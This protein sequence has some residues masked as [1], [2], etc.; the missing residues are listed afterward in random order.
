M[1]INLDGDIVNECKSLLDN[2]DESIECINTE[3]IAKQD[4]VYLP[5]IF[6]T[7]SIEEKFRKLIEQLKKLE[8]NRILYNNGATDTKTIK[9]TLNEINSDIAY[10]DIKD[11]YESYVDKANEK[12]KEDAI[13]A[14]IK[15]E[16]E[17]SH[18]KLVNYE[19][20]KSN[21]HIAMDA[22]NDD[23]SYIFFSRNRLSLE[24]RDGKYILLSRGQSV[25]PKQ[26]SVGERNAIALCYFFSDIMKNQEE[27]QVYGIPHLLV[28]DD[29]I[30]SY[31][32]E[33]RVG[34][35]SYL[36]YELCKFTAGN[37]ET[38]GLIMTHDLQ[39]LFD[40]N[41]FS[42]EIVDLC[43]NKFTGVGK[44]KVLLKELCNQ[45]LEYINPERRQEYTTLLGNIYN[46][47]LDGSVEYE[48][49][50]GNMMRRVLEAYG[51]FCYK[52]GIEQLS[53]DSEILNELGEPYNRY[54]EN[55]M[56]RIVLNSE[57]HLKER[58][59]TLDSTNFFD[60][61]SVGEK[62][63]T[64]RDVICMMYKLNKLHLLKHL[65]GK[66]GAEQIIE[67]WCTDIEKRTV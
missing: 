55:L 18:K 59:Q 45:N 6:L 62:K 26:I 28:I 50:I 52:K 43:T 54:F 49:S 7:V 39:T 4:N 36:R 1:Y 27:K 66:T 51:T 10:Y 57:S 53:T 44:H 14:G 61:I 47:G 32:M 2:F 31:D 24:Y 42:E 58:V 21:V 38:K 15:N 13:L 46:F 56:Y 30:S 48:L 60:F 63:R 11:I 8:E 65:S 35:L 33:N 25:T 16:L 23:L 9:S 5:R 40:C 34:I 12:N 41:K 22:I 19:T 67:S 64:A 37:L 29:P 17:E 3:I 20:Q